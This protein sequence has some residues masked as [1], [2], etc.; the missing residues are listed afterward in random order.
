M[1]LLTSA[2]SSRN[3][4][5]EPDFL[6][7]LEEMGDGRT[8]TVLAFLFVLACSFRRATIFP[9]GDIF[10]GA[11]NG[12]D[13]LTTSG[14]NLTVPDQWNA[15]TLGEN[16]AP[17]SW[18]WNVLL[19]LAAHGL[20]SYGF[21]LLTF[22]TC[23][24]TSLLLWAYL[25]RIDMPPMTAFLTLVLCWLTV[26]AAFMNGRATSSDFLMLMSFLYLSRRLR[27]K[28]VHLIMISFLLTVLWINLHL[29]GLVAVGV[30]PAVVYALLNEEPVKRRLGIAAL[31]FFASAAAVPLTPFGFGIFQKVMGV[32]SA[33]KGM[34]VEWSSVFD[35]PQASIGTIELL[36][37]SGVLLFILLRRKSFLC[38]LAVL[39]L[40]V[41]SATTIRFT[42]YLL[43][44]VLA[45]LSC[46]RYHPEFPAVFRRFN[47][48][49][50]IM[51]AVLF[52]FAAVMG[53]I[54]VVSGVQVA[55]DP[56]HMLPVHASDFNAVPHGAVVASAQS[57]GSE[58]VLYRPDVLVT[59][60]GRNDLM[61]R[62]RFTKAN[63]ILSW[64]DT[65]QLSEWLKTYHVTV[66]FSE[67]TDANAAAVKANMVKLGWAE[68]QSGNASL[69]LAPTK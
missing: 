64:K 24:A 30:F 61:G 48:P 63:L 8:V 52:T 45:A 50:L 36:L 31:T 18:L 51:K 16:W 47:R 11:R 33:S 41:V 26:M 28:P 6:D 46:F 35:N 57:A 9:E 55:A 15:V 10:W 54:A 62:E 12:W 22:G 40:A 53:V 56:E 58:M 69:F 5:T 14:L 34:I 59:L 25:R 19:G 20:G 3:N 44:V 39:V 27:S 60:D 23:L 32:D 13:I 4:T 38:A 21:A 68:E 43:T 67:A 37:A 7:R 1:S 2:S 49:K 66:V 29:S 17:N 65:G 42:P